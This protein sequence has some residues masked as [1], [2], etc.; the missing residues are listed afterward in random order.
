MARS[1]FIICCCITVLYV[2][3]VMASEVSPSK[4]LDSFGPKS[5]TIVRAMQE[6]LRTFY[7]QTAS[8]LYI[9]VGSNL[10]AADS[11]VSEL[12]DQLVHIESGKL[13]LTFVI[14]NGTTPL[15][16]NYR[17]TYNLFVVDNYDAFR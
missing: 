14:E 8:T 11:F 12:V 7:Y 16:Q 6:I 9:K 5:M 17:R 15:Y 3:Y 10:T 13:F 4:K 1:D 2:A